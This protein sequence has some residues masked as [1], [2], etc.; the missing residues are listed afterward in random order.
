MSVL[1]LLAQD[2][3]ITYSKVV[4]NKIGVNSAILL[5]ALCSYQNSFNN[6]AFFKEQEKISDDT[7]LSIYEIRQATKKLVDC[8]ILE[9]ERKGLPAKNYYFIV[10]DKLFEILSARCEKFKHLD[11]KNL[12]I[13]NNNTKNNNTKNNNTMSN[14]AR[15]DVD[16]NLYIVDSI[17]E[18]G[19][20]VGQCPNIIF[21]SN[22]ISLS[23]SKSEGGMGE[24]KAE[25]TD[26]EYAVSSPTSST[27]QNPHPKKEI[28]ELKPNKPIPPIQ[29]ETEKPF[30]IN[31]E[32]PMERFIKKWGLNALNTSPY[33]YAKLGG[34]DWDKLS[35]K[36]ETSNFL[37]QQK[38]LTFFTKNY[39]AILEGYYDDYKKPNPQRPLSNNERIAQKIDEEKERKHKEWQQY[40]EEA[41]KAKERQRRKL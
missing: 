13:I 15:E 37:K 26:I 17:I 9:I 36:I 40:E 29:E 23:N 33:E 10:E 41:R 30:D 3:F 2:N 31:E 32:T 5:G 19:T 6:D 7:C 25:K 20:S 18:K 16:K 38:S 28:K 11:I 34:I 27:S 24:T 12:D 21:N 22:S 8:G 35:E 1:K 39:Y 4:A 14:N